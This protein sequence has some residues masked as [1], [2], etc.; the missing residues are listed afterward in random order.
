MTTNMM[1]ATPMPVYLVVVIAVVAVV[2]TTVTTTVIVSAFEVLKD[3]NP[4]RP[5]SYPNDFIHLTTKSSSCG[6]QQQQQ[7][8]GGGDKDDQHDQNDQVL[9]F[10]EDVD[11]GNNQAGPWITD[12]TTDGT[13]NVTASRLKEAAPKM[14]SNN[15]MNPNAIVMTNDG[16]L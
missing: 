4:G 11:Y 12:G 7:Q 6:K 13:I 14:A 5:S 9:F 1:I 2:A 8:Q 10:V 15:N 16:K 3:I